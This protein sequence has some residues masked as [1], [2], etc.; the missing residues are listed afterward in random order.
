MEMGKMKNDFFQ[1]VIFGVTGDLSRRKVLPAIGRLILKQKLPSKLQIIGVG[2]QQFSVDELLA[3][4]EEFLDQDET[5]SVREKL[6]KIMF[7]FSMDLKN[8]AQYTDLKKYLDK[9][10]TPKT[11]RL[12]CFLT[13]AD[14]FQDIVIG[15]GEVGLNSS[16]NSSDNLPRILIEKP[17]GEDLASAKALANTI[18]KYFQKEQVYLVDHYLF[19]AP[20]QNLLKLRFKNPIF[21]T[22]WQ[23]DLIESVKIGIYEDFGISNRIEFYEKTGALK[24]VAQN[25]LLELLAI[26]MME[27]P[28]ERNQEAL[29]QQ[30]LKFLNSIIPVK[31][32]QATRAQYYG[33]REEVGNSQSTTETFIRLELKSDNKKWS[34]TKM[35]VE[36]G[37]ALDSKNTQIELVVKPLE[38]GDS[39]NIITIQ[40]QPSMKVNMKLWSKNLN[41]DELM[42]LDLQTK[43]LEYLNTDYESMFLAMIHGERSFFVPIQEALTLW[44]IIEPLITQGKDVG[45]DLLFYKQGTKAE[46]II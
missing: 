29:H 4:M 38:S 43:S 24:D 21:Q 35:I 33:Y 40:L 11:Q 7:T 27:C 32:N 16:M 25:H 46:Q 28:T 39:K 18:D 41:S 26:M 31:N 6:A 10:A 44:R 42:S 14:I 20:V 8:P 13:P 3:S 36:T 30:K 19:K 22:L 1:L 17:F 2:R 9:L 23:N 45:G 34:Q 5:E 15:L 37:K 12:F